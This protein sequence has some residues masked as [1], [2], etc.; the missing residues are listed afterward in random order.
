MQLITYV[1]IFS[2]FAI[3][4]GRFLKITF[5]AL[6]KDLGITLRACSLLIV[7]KIQLLCIWTQI[8]GHFSFACNAYQLFLVSQLHIQVF[9]IFTPCISVHN[10]ELLA[11]YIAMQVHAE[12]LLYI[13]ANNKSKMKL[14]IVVVV[15]SHVCVSM[16]MYPPQEH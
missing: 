13:K 3:N 5:F 6:H 7:S 11:S 1:H 15:K 8:Y 16:S 14:H 12:D 4:I 2:G 10:L 9:I